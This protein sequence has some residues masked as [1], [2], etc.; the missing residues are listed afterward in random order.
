V[1]ENVSAPHVHACINVGR[2]HGKG[3]GLRRKTKT[4]RKDG[5]K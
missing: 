5:T 1:L 3:I 2:K 4:E